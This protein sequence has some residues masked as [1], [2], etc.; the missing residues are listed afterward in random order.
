MLV[1]DDD[2]DDLVVGCVIP[3]LLASL[4]TKAFETDMLIIIIVK[5]KGK[6]WNHMELFFVA[7]KTGLQSAHVNFVYLNEFE[8]TLE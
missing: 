3:V 2:D 7:V 5:Y 4:W 8:T 1:T 6:S